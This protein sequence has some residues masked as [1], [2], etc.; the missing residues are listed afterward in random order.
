MFSFLFGVETVFVTN[1]LL[2]FPVSIS[3]SFYL[4]L[5]FFFSIQVEIKITKV[6]IDLLNYVFSNY[7]IFKNSLGFSQRCQTDH[8]LDRR[9]QQVLLGNPGTDDGPKLPVE[10]GLRKTGIAHRLQSGKQ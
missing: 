7:S 5:L 9:D 8:G 10:T 1:L 2:S 6:L 3:L 4:F